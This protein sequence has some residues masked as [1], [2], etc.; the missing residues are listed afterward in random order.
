MIKK[1]YKSTIF[2]I[3]E[4]FN[5]FATN[6]CESLKVFKKHP[7]G[8]VEETALNTLDHLVTILTAVNFKTKTYTLQKTNLK[9]LD[10]EDG[11]YE[12]RNLIKD[13]IHHVPMFG[14]LGIYTA[15]IC[16]MIQ[17][18]RLIM[19]CE[20]R[21]LSYLF[22]CVNTSIAHIKHIAE[23]HMGE[24]SIQDKLKH[25][26]SDQVKVLIDVLREFKSR[27]EQE[28]CSI[29]FVERRFTA[30]ILYHILKMMGEDEEFAYIKPDF[31]VGYHN[32]PYNTTRE[33]LFVAKQNKKVVKA[34]S[35][36]ELNLVVSSN[37]LEE[38]IDIPNCTLVVKFNKPMTYR[39][40]VQSKGRARHK[41]SFYYILVEDGE[42]QRFTQNYCMFREVERILNEVRSLTLKI[43]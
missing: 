40:Y 28:L 33:G 6:P 41:E 42:C 19:H 9:P 20:D 15:S 8:I 38:G 17:L 23:E 22:N 18:Q 16:Y 11:L 31:M 35:N 24:C 5:R 29:V 26:V 14:T 25:H 10:P 2:N 7:I 12:L 27:S 39:S 32:S 13:F 21:N 3:Y 36:R 1:N 30:K 37:V 4:F 34:F 43:F